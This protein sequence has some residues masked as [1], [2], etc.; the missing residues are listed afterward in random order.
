MWLLCILELPLEAVTPGSIS[1]GLLCWPDNIS[2]LSWTKL[3]LAG[4]RRGV[5]GTS[6]WWLEIGEGSLLRLAPP[7]LKWGTVT[8]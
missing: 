8:Y 6:M 7:P 4:T 2:Q 5:G 1:A 3:A